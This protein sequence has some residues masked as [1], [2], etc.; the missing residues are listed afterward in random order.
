MGQLT[1]LDGDG[2]PLPHELKIQRADHGSRIFIL[3][4]IVTVSSGAIIIWLLPDSPATASFLT[5]REKDILC[6]R[7]ENDSGGLGNIQTAES[8]QKKYLIAALTDWKIWLSVIVYWGN[9]ISTYGYDTHLKYVS[10]RV[11]IK[12][13]WA[14]SSTPCHPSFMNLATLPRTRSCLRFQSMSSPC[15]LHYQQLSSLIEPAIAP[16]SLY[17][18]SWSLQS[19]TSDYWLFRTRTYPEQ[20]TA[21]S[22]LLRRDSIQPFAAF[23]HG[24]V[25]SQKPTYVLVPS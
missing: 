25:S 11:M 8:F 18:R 10:P 21:C 12:L 14:G 20:R 4:G 17:I 19:V 24:M 5:A 6:Q 1:L 23:S 9:S 22:S 16:T 15:S 7:L 2:P 3:E 13:T